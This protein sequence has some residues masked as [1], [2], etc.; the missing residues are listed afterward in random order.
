M[1]KNSTITYTETI[2]EN[3]N[4]ESGNIVVPEGVT[5]IGDHAFAGSSI[6]NVQLPWTLVTIGYCSFSNC[7]NLTRLE[8]PKGVKE[9]GYGAFSGC[10]NL[11]YISFPDTVISI[12]GDLFSRCTGL[13]R[14]SVPLHLVFEAAMETPPDVVI[15][16][17]R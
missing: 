6:E 3:V 8:I 14:I 13:K 10:K 12:K 2:L 15:E 17:I 5:T 7:V 9:I 4:H 16:V 11:E 1:I